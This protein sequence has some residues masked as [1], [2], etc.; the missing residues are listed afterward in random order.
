MV[1]L[2]YTV[3][4]EGSALHNGGAVILV[5]DSCSGHNLCSVRVLLPLI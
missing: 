5:F 4:F 3:S 1:C 2:L